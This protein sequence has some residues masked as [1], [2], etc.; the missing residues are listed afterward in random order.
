LTFATV[1]TSGI[2]C[3]TT[4]GQIVVT[5]PQ[6]A[7][8]TIAGRVVNG[9]IRTENLQVQ[10]TQSSTRRLDATVGGGGPEIRLE[11]TNGEVRVV[12]R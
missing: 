7:K 6:N 11:T 12:G 4:N 8:A 10:S 9:D 3:K 5:I 1:G 2:R